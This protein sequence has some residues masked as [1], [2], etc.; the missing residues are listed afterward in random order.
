MKCIQT[1]KRYIL[2]CD[3]CYQHSLSTNLFIPCISFVTFIRSIG[4]E[5]CPN[6]KRCRNSSRAC[7]IFSSFDLIF[8]TYCQRLSSLFLLAQKQSFFQFYDFPCT[9]YG[10]TSKAMWKQRTTEIKS[11]RER[12]RS[13]ERVREETNRFRGYQPSV[14]RIKIDI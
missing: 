2:M 4:F 11:E 10:H 3:V 8:Y 12:K 9:R 14:F 7:K 13:K 1:S 5:T 6:Y